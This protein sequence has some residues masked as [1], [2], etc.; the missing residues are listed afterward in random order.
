MTQLVTPPPCHA[1]ATEAEE[2]ATG[3]AP[4]RFSG[5]ARWFHGSGLVPL[6]E[7][8]SPLAAAVDEALA[9]YIAE[10]AWNERAAAAD[11]LKVSAAWPHD[12]PLQ[13]I[14][15]CPRRLRQ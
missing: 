10:A 6:W 11:P 15:P 3:A 7:L 2:A 5:D 13:D 8:I 4:Q 1:A 12:Q 9:R 14:A